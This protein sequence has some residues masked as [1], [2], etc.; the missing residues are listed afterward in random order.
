MWAI[1][2]GDCITAMRKMPDNSVDAI[3]TDPPYELGFMGKGW[4]SSGIAYNVE[5][6]RECLRVLNPG[7]HLLAFGGT[8]TY[9]RMACAIED[10][11]FEIR[12]SI[13]WIYG[14]GF[15]K[16]RD[17]SKAIDSEADAE[18]EPGVPGR[19]A[20]RRP[21]AEV[22]AVN[23]YHDGVGD[24][25][26][27][28]VTAP[29]TDEAKEWAGWGTALKPAHEPIIMARKP[30]AAKTVAGNVLE[31]GT[32]GINID[33]CRIGSDG[34]GTHCSNRDA[35]GQCLGHDNAGRS[36]SGATVHAAESNSGRWPANI[37]L[38]EE[39]GAELDAQSGMLKSGAHKA[40]YGTVGQ[41]G[42][43]GNAYQ[44]KEL[45]VN[46]GGA[47]RF[48]YCAKASKKERP[49]VDG[50]AHPTV[51]P[52]ALMRWLVK[53]VTPVGGIVLDPFAGS[54]ATAE[55]CELEHFDSVMIELEP[56]HVKLINHRM[57]PYLEEAA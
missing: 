3:V 25:S 10:A 8:R 40:D 9:H 47:S 4:D 42:M 39:A 17:I 36:T 24:S 12:D 1:T 57:A 6:W 50:I 56:D 29:A 27:A 16:S 34:G 44:G 30:L 55:A 46:Y 52:L 38:D 37:I 26:T 21:R 14:S 23:A 31:F 48:F 53:L 5:V 2:T 41:T 32:G 45:Q 28:L 20:A 13:H 51:K 54:G 18:R 7:G 35:S 33:G 19:Y 11:G 49:T 15:P 22:P 43:F